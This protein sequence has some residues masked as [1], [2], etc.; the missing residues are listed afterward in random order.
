[1]IHPLIR[2]NQ[3]PFR[4]SQMGYGIFG[5]DSQAVGGDQFR[6]SMIDFRIQMIGPSC[7]DNTLCTRF[8]HIRKDFLT[9]SLNIFS[10]SGHFRPA[11]F[12]RP[13]HFFFRQLGKFFDQF[14]F[15]N[16]QISE[17]HK[18]IAQ[19]CF[20]AADFIH[21]ILDVFRIGGDDRAVVMI[22]GIRRLISFVKESGIE[23]EVNTLLNQPGYMSMGQLGRIAFGFAGDGF[24]SQ[25]IDAVRG[26]GGEN[27]LIFQF[28]KKGIPE[29]IILIHV[30]HAGNPH[31]SSF[32]FI[33]RQRF[34]GKQPFQLIFKQVGN[35]AWILRL[36][37]TSF[38]AVAGDIL[39]SAGKTVYGKTAVIGTALTFCHARFK[40]QGIDLVDV[41]HGGLITGAVIVTG[42]Q[43]GSESS[44]D[45]GDIGTDSLAVRNFF[46]ASQHGIIIKSAA[47]NNDPVPQLRG[48]RYL[49]YLK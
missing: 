13:E 7:K 11:L 5:K 36:S 15:G 14:L 45:T 24:D 49:D 19:D 31:T 21:I 1:M 35:L 43:G 33:C 17:S 48:I 12:R 25:L 4:L 8:F 37:Q 40:L 30:Q 22:A 2:Y 27:H 20:A 46:K 23:D 16:F 44:H 26:A 38:T 18:W 9:F 41:Q 3:R 47:L 29:R 10:G 28:C 39:A 32:R 6:N 34:I 42:D